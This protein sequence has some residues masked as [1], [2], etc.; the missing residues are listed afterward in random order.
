MS[1]ANFEGE[2]G[3]ARPLYRGKKK[4]PFSMKTPWLLVSYFYRGREKTIN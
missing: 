4:G 3:G 1:T 2:G